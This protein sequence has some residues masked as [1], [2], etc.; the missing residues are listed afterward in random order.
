MDTMDIIIY[1]GRISRC[2]K[3]E[4]IREFRNRRSRV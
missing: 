3:R 1:A 2:M 4:L